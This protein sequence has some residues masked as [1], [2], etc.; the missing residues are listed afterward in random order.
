MLR[1]HCEAVCLLAFASVSIANRSSVVT[2]TRSI[3]ALAFPLGSGGLPGLFGFCFCVCVCFKA[4]EL[5]DVC[6]ELFLT[7]IMY[8]NNY[9]ESRYFWGTI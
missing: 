6:H 1:I 4:S 8:P 9:A 7:V 3:T 5:L 2:R